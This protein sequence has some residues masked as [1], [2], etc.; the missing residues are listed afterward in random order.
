MFQEYY[1][2]TQA[3]FSKS[4]A[5]S[6]LFPTG[7]QKELAARLTYLVRERGFGLITGEVGSGKSTAVRAFTASLDPNRYLV[8]Y[9]TNP[10]TGIT[11]IYRDLLLALGHEPP[12]S[13]PR[14]VARL[15]EAF[16][17]LLNAKRRVPIVILDE[18]HLLAPILLE[19]L[20]LL[21]SDQ[22]DSQSLATV[23]LVGHPD[24]RRTLHLAVHEAFSQRLAVRYHLGPLDLAETVGYVRHHV[25]AA[26]YTTGPL[27]TDD[28]VAR[29]YEYTKG[30][31]RRINQVCT[32][33]LMA[34]LIDQKQLLDETTV[35]KAIAEL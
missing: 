13:R 12:F 32:T 21:F 6:D 35:R 23:L 34:G 26:G 31:P 1:G 15:R 22:M 8:L 20:R 14:L 24:L 4:I 25:R 17:D 19:Q 33:A 29:I 5:T 3:P 28:A 2:F 7:G 11:G 16:A 18:A 27:F 30:L 10:T 9:L